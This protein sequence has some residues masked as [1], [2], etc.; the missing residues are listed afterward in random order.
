[1]NKKKFLLVGFGIDKNNWGN[2]GTSLALLSLL[3]AKGIVN[4]F[5][6]AKEKNIR[7]V[8]YP[9]QKISGKLSWELYNFSQKSPTSKAG[10]FSAYLSSK[11]L[12]I[13][14]FIKE[15][16]ADSADFILN[17]IEHTPYLRSLV[18]RINDCD[19]VVINGEGDA[20]FTTPPRRTYLFLLAIIALAARLEKKTHFLNSIFSPSPNN[21]VDNSTI[22]ITR[23][24]LKSCSTITV[25]DPLSQSFVRE[26]LPELSS[27]LVPD[28]LFAWNQLYLKNL[29]SNTQDNKALLFPFLDGAPVFDY[30]IISRPYVVIAGSSRIEGTSAHAIS[31]YSRLISKI[32]S[33]GMQVICCQPGPGDEILQIAAKYT[34]VP[35]VKGSIPIMAA[36]TLLSNAECFISGR[37]HPSIL[38]SCGGTPCIFL[39]S[40]SHKNLGLQELLGYEYPH[41]Y[42]CPPSEIETD[43]IL[44]ELSKLSGNQ[45]IRESLY[46]KS[47]ELSIQ[48]QAF[49]DIHF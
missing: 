11:F 33:Q 44:E 42:T 1:M 8:S 46:A 29:S 21:T 7:L 6:F 17:N 13:G 38:S 28:A 30:D 24:T 3:S 47:A 36:A 39:S 35:Y 45:S 31:S 49:F 14:E 16:P 37:Y 26:H 41:Q 48:V 22:E 15:E 40:N 20:I 9:L 23:E 10:A 27:L 12:D 25:R 2:R 19:E 32:K 43:H 5:I 18:E 34:S 4:G